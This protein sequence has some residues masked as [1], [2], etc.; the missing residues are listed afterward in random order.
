M[1]TRTQKVDYLQDVC[2]LMPFKMGDADSEAKTVSRSMF[3]LGR[4]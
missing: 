1:L 3:F 2:R 4:I